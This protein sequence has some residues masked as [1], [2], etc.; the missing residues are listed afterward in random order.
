MLTVM[1]PVHSQN[2]TTLP[3]NAGSVIN[4]IWVSTT[5]TAIAAFKKEIHSEKFIA[6]AI[7]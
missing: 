6:V 5:R 1:K 4:G 3:S 2:C 7:D